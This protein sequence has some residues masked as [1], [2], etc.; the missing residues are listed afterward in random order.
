M[1]PYINFLYF[2][3]SL[4][5]LIPAVIFGFFKRFW[6]AWLVIATIFMLMIQYSD[7]NKEHP[8]IVPGIVLVLGYAVIQWLIAISF[9]QIRKRGVNKTALYIAL[10]LS[11]LPL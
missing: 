3:I 1:T 10:L 9:L 11:I 7:I 5:A 6:K 8:T 4:Y 2:G